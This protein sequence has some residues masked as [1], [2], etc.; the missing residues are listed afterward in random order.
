MIDETPNPDYEVQNEYKLSLND[1]PYL[2]RIDIIEE[3]LIF[4]CTPIED[5]PRFYYTYKCTLSSLRKMSKAFHLY[6]SLTEVLYLFEELDKSKLISLE[7]PDDTNYNISD[8]ES[9]FSISNIKK[10]ESPFEFINLVVKL[11]VLVKEEVMVFPLEKKAMKQNTKI[12][13]NLKDEI[14]KIYQDFNSV[15]IKYENKIDS[16]KKEVKLLRNENTN[17]R[18]QISELINKIEEL[19]NLL[20]RNNNNKKSVNSI[21][22]LINRVE[23]L[24]EWKNDSNKNINITIDSQQIKNDNQINNK[25]EKN[26]K[27]KSISKREKKEENKENKE[28]K[29]KEGNEGKEVKKKIFNF[30]KSSGDKNNSEENDG[31]EEEEEEEES[32]NGVKEKEK[33][34]EDEKEDRKEKKRKENC[35]DNNKDI[36]ISEEEE[37]EDGEEEE[38]K[39]II[40]NNR[41]SFNMNMKFKEKLMKSLISQ[42]NIIRNT[43]EIDFL[44]NKLIKLN[45]LAFTLLYK[46]SQ[47]TDNCKSFHQKCD[48][49]KNILLFILTSKNY[50]FGGYTSAG[51]DSSGNAKKDMESFLF[52]VDFQKIYDIKEE[53]YAIFCN[54]NCGP[55]F[56]GKSDGL[57]N[58]CVPDKY[59]RNYSSTCKKGVPFNT[60]EPFELNHGEKEFQVMEL[61]VYKI[62]R[63]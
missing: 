15:E 52:S 38:E 19:K 45:P 36:S 32:E 11:F 3:T 53:Q 2:L 31:L 49:Q 30:E 62:D 20:N 51:F 29:E 35:K 7:V 22:D 16:L 43:F 25:E 57:Y 55:I 44:L 47:D 10:N 5:K 42:S 63:N 33:L 9:Y 54:K 18:N 8:N 58:I 23:K 61:E 17:F 37:E 27:H 6:Q 48:G 59:F 4:T 40:N 60:T 34:E 26:E 13:A 14:R 12:I 21:Q 1:K 50:I 24:E 39:E 28:N 56:C 41:T 46:G